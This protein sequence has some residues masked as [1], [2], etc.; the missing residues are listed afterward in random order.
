MRIELQTAYVLHTRPYRDT[1]LLVDFFTPDLGRIGAVAR[2]VRQA[3]GGKRTLLNPFNCLLISLQGKQD[4]KLLTALEA[5]GPGYFLTG[6][7]LYSG[8]YLNELLTR[9]LPEMDPHTQL[10]YAYQDCL[11]QLHS[12]VE[13]EPLL[14]N[15]ELN[16]L[17]ELGYAI[18]FEMDAHTGEKISAEGWYQFDIQTGFYLDQFLAETKSRHEEQVPNHLF[19]GEALLAIASRDFSQ[20]ETR[21]TAKRLSRLMLQPLLGSRPLKSRELFIAPRT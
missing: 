14:R 17:A 20:A 7:Q 12:G 18:N 2:G 9:L 1:S 8:F 16:L 13:L 10:F 5:S 21:M 15:F 6:S 19:V 4:L 11:Q 3:K